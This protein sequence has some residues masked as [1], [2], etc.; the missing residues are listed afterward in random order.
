[1]RQGEGEGRG[2]R[3]KERDTEKSTLTVFGKANTDQ[4]GLHE[5]PRLKKR[6]RN[7]Y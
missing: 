1:M 2:K 6:K 3:E 4:R 5:R 7:G